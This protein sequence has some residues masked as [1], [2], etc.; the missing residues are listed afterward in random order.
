MGRG[1]LR[2]STQMT[3]SEKSKLLSRI[4]LFA[5]ALLLGMG[6][7][8]IM[9]P[10]L[11]VLVASAVVS[12]SLYPAYE[13]VHR[14]IPNVSLAAL[15]TVLLLLLVILL[16]ATY[17][18]TTL[19]GELRDAYSALEHDSRQE[20]GWSAYLSHFVDL[21]I[22]WIA[23]RTGMTAPS[24]KSMLVERAESL[25]AASLRWLSSLLT[26]LASTLGKLLFVLFVT[27]FLFQSGDRVRN[28]ATRYLPIE[29]HRLNRLLDVMQNAIIANIY[30]MIAVGAVQG[31]LVGVGFAI[32]GLRSP[33][34]WGLVGAV[35]SLIPVVG[36]ALVWVPGVII[37]L[38]S[39]TWGK[40]L[41]L[42]AWGVLVVGM[43]DNFVRPWVLRRGVELSTLSIFLSLMGGVQVF[44]FIGLFAGPIIFTMA[45]VVVKMLHEE[46]LEWEG[47]PVPIAGEPPIGDAADAPPP[48]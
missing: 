13:A 33:V 7:F 35:A 45:Y 42:I 44:G 31:L 18:A 43:S 34:L 40:A 6:V 32:C 23:A 14:R 48:A 19:T 15:A 27:F 9:R 30:G 28:A 16:P 1:A 46:R 2:S 12:I 5:L 17:L 36:T 11:E 4:F 20:G 21:P 26:N 24:L 41:F 39:G 3:Q 22:Q 8:F 47:R 29:D 37:L 38:I 10:F 25:S